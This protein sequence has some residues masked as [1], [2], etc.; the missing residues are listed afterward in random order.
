MPRRKRTDRS[1]R[2]RPPQGGYGVCGRLFELC[3]PDGALQVDGASVEAPI[4]IASSGDTVATA[5][6]T[7][8]SPG[9]DGT[10]PAGGTSPGVGSD[11]VGTPVPALDVPGSGSAPSGG[12][13]DPGAVLPIEADGPGSVAAALAS[14]ELPL[15]GFRALV[16]LILGAL[17]VAGG[18]LLCRSAAVAGLR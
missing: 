11:P 3:A 8:E 10:A 14:G 2:R 15:T 7:G 4:R 12:G 1:R 16:P 6:E 9:D 17:L 5:S 13:E 18:Q